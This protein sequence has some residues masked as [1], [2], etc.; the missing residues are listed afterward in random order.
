M[1]SSQDGSNDALE[2][3]YKEQ[4][5]SVIE[6]LVRFTDGVDRQAMVHRMAEKLNIEEAILWEE[7]SRLRRTRNKQKKYRQ[8]F[9]E[10]NIDA[11]LSADKRVA[12]QSRTAELELIRIMILH[13][14][15]IKFIFNFMRLDDFHDPEAHAMATTLHD[16]LSREMP[17]E[18]ESLIHLFNDPEQASFVSTV[19]NARKVKIEEIDYRR[20]SADCMTRLQKYMIDD[21]IRELKN[22]IK[23]REKKRRQCNRSN[24]TILRIPTTITTIEA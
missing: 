19:V 24:G 6:T 23:E 5:R 20:W 14:D 15:A 10:P 8:Q 13:W 21:H 4:I 1:K 18:P 3:D 17:L 22:Q 7:V 11:V 16:L 9:S 2:K 12:E